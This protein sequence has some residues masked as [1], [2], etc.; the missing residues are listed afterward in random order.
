MGKDPRVTHLS[1][2]KRR[3]TSRTS[4]A[5]LL[6]EAKTRRVEAAGLLSQFLAV[7]VTRS[8]IELR[9]SGTG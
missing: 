5:L 3:T 6:A 8:A 4:H 9:L 7:R 2:A 1:S